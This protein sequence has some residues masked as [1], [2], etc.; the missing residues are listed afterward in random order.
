[1][2]ILEYRTDWIAFEAIKIAEHN[3]VYIANLS[4]TAIKIREVFKNETEG[5][6]NDAFDNDGFNIGQLSE[7]IQRFWLSMPEDLFPSQIRVPAE[8]KLR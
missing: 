5:L 2:T 7:S 1:M 6:S 3:G 8:N 4:K